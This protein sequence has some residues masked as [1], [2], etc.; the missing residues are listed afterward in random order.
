METVTTELE[1]SGY[2]AMLAPAGAELQRIAERANRLLAVTTELASAATALDV[3]R[4]TLGIGLGVVEAARGT[5]GCVVPGGVNVIHTVGFD[6]AAQRVL[7]G[8]QVGDVGALTHCV[9]TGEPL[10][11]RSALEYQTR[12]PWAYSK[13]G[14]VSPSQAFA[15]LPLIH[16]NKVIGGIGLSFAQPTAFGA[17]DRAFTLLLARAAAGALARAMTFDAA[18]ERSREA[19]V[20]ARAREDMLSIVAHDLRNPLNLLAGTAQLLVDDDLP[21]PKR[22]DLLNVSVRATH[23]MNRLIGDLLDA[24][25]IQNGALP[26]HVESCPVESILSQIDETMRPLA[27]QAGIDFHVLLRAPAGACVVV[28]GVRIVQALGNLVANALKFTPRGGQV[29]VSA[30][31]GRRIVAFGVSDSGPGLSAESRGHLFERFWQAKTDRRGVGL[32]LTIVKGIAEAHGGRVVVRSILGTGS[33]FA[34]VCPR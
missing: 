1:A 31:F 32:G 26:V 25:R 22:R 18:N 17:A 15:G 33:T 29:V 4:V 2:S 23:Q 9:L 14:S 27:E 19:D 28:D 30:S 8:L 21:A 6:A 34:V 24:K 10:Y 3:A 13:I 5:F 16:E 12:F 7:L 11:L 20:L